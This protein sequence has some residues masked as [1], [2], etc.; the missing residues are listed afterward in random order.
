MRDAE[1]DKHAAVA[2]LILRFFLGIFLLQWGIEK[3]ILPGSAARIANAFYGVS[4]PTA[5]SYALG[6]AEIILS[7]AFLLGLFRTVSYGLALLVHTVTVLV[8]WR[9]LL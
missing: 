9:Q 4:L 7:L 8:S 2:L 6:T 5:A 3:V 1:A